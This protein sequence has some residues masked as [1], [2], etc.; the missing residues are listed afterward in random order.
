[1]ME[2]AAEF[3]F[4]EDDLRFKLPFGMVLA[5]PSSSGKTT[6]LTKFLAEA[7]HLIIPAPSSILYCYGEYN[8]NV[9][10]LQK[11]G[12]N[13]YFGV[14]TEEVLQRQP[15]PFVLVLD[16]LML[17]IEERFLSELFTKKS[18]HQQF[19][20]ILVLQDLFDRKVRVARQNSQYL[21]LM[22]APNSAL[23]IRNIGVQLFPRQ[24]DFFLQSYKDATSKKYGYLVLDLH[25][26]SNP[27]LQLRTNIFEEDEEKLIY[28]PK[29]VS[30]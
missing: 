16:D 22:R 17:S 6:F 30:I 10:V 13:V 19:A 3:V 11:M 12:I 24:L 14:P 18:H 8:P 27:L 9:A 7:Q 23:A 20:V 15:K 5:G 4:S 1:M 29:N 25:A 21:V 2:S 28:L 26:A